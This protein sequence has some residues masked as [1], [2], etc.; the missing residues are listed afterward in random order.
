MTGLKRKLAFVHTAAPAIQPVMQF[1]S[2]AAPD[3]DITNLMEDG[4]LRLLA[5]RKHDTVFARLREMIGAARTVYGAEL[6]M[7]TCS[8]VPLTMARDISKES[9]LPVI[10]I[11]GP[12]ARRAVEAGSRIGVAVTFRPT[13][14]PTSKLLRETAA[15]MGREVELVIQMVEGAY[16]ALF[17]GDLATHD[18]LLLDGIRELAAKGVDS[19]V[20]AQVSMARVREAARDEV[21]VP[22]FSS[23]DTSLTA[24][25]E[26]LTE[27]TASGT[28]SSRA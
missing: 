6:V 8:S 25:R 11:D 13:I 2:Q 10:K 24:I 23:L 28:G 16:D 19:I 20:L 21:S 4:L 15:T 3:L 5:E 22:V 1:Y 9:G 27:P 7:I 14:E 12:M 17:A 26:L 18:R